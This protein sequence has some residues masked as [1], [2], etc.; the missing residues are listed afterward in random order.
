VNTATTIVL[1]LGLIMAGSIATKLFEVFLK[2]VTFLFFVV[3]VLC[4]FALIL[5]PL[6]KL[7]A[8]LGINST[9]IL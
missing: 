1:A 6:I 2:A 7:L 3:L 5:V 8:T 4:G 9:V